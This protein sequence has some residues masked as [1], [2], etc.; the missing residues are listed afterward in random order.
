MNKRHVFT[1]DTALTIR[2]TFAAPGDQPTAGQPAE[3]PI[4]TL[5]GWAIRYNVPSSDRGGFK[6]KLLPG[7]ANF[8][9]PTFA[10][11]H[12]DFRGVIGST[13]NGTLRLF[14][15]DQGVRVEIDLPD[16]TT[17]RDVEELVE[18]G[19]VGGMSFA[20][21]GEPDSQETTENGQTVVTV[22]RFECD[23]VTVTPI[24]A[25]VQTSIGIQA[26]NVPE[27]EP[28]DYSRELTP[29][30]LKLEAYRLSNYRLD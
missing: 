6:V 9:A 14:P 16:T 5:E 4:A 26:D 10:L 30:L 25:F 27:D 13:Q 28:Q 18:N 17:G 29:H 24:P 8:A 22:S 7:S 21:V 23:E 15:D 2:R 20:M 3:R 19:Y 11:Y 1:T 12:H